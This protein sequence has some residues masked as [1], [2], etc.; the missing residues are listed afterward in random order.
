MQKRDDDEGPRGFDRKL[1]PKKIIA[2]DERDGELF[3][4]M[5]WKDCDKVS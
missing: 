5:M 3:F 2:A 1:E 4:F